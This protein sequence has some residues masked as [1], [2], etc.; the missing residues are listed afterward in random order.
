VFRPACPCP[1]LACPQSF[2]GRIATALAL[3][4]S[5]SA[6]ELGGMHWEVRK[7][8]APMSDGSC[9]GKEWV[10]P[11]V[12]PRSADG[13]EQLLHDNDYDFDNAFVDWAY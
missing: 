1:D 9:P 7:R 5:L 10:S 8:A 4:A 2:Y 13:D 11:P 6:F 3:L 12:S